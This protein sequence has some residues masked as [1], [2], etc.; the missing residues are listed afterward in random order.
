[1]H[2]SSGNLENLENQSKSQ[3]SADPGGSRVVKMSIYKE[4]PSSPDGRQIMF[5]DSS[6]LFIE[7][8][9]PGNDIFKETGEIPVVPE[10]LEA[11]VFFSVSGKL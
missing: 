7:A 10:C 1:M 6:D 3:I 2:H 11:V 9:D 4:K 5:R 8:M